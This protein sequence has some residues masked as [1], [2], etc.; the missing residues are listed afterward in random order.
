MISFS[1]SSVGAIT[2]VVASVALAPTTSVLIKVAIVLVL[3]IASHYIFDAIPHGHYKYS[4][5]KPTPNQRVILLL[6]TVGAFVLLWLLTLSVAGFG[7]ALL[8]VTVGMAGA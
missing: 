1:H 4:F 8:L 6:D 3:S 7:L 5:K 2:G